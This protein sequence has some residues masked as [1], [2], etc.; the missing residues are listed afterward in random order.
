M[1]VEECIGGGAMEMGPADKSTKEFQC[2]W[3]ME[4]LELA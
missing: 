2:V 1:L 4:R 3:E